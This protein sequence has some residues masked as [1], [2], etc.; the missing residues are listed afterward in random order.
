ME[1]SIQNRQQGTLIIHKGQQIKIKIK[2]V[3]RRGSTI[4]INATLPPTEKFDEEGPVEVSAEI[5]DTSHIQI[6]YFIGKYSTLEVNWLV[7]KCTFKNP[8]NIISFRTY[9][10]DES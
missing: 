10:V 8:E 9:V 5:L 7:D 3:D 1:G 6:E 2:E 4:R